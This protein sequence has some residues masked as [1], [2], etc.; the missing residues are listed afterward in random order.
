MSQLVS[1]PCVATVKRPDRTFTRE[2]VLVWDPAD[3]LRMTFETPATGTMDEGFHTFDI[4]DDVDMADNGPTVTW[5]GLF[6]SFAPLAWYLQMVIV[7]AAKA[8]AIDTELNA[9]H[10]P[11]AS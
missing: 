4:K 10:T 5:M 6:L 9:M 7:T 1:T 3:P 8:A 2:G 11:A